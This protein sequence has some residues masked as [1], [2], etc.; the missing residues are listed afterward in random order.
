M[1]TSR[2]FFEEKINALHRVVESRNK[3]ITDLKLQVNALEQYSRRSHLRIHGLR[4]GPDEDCPSAVASLLSS[5]LKTRDGQSLVV[6][7]KDI[8]AAHPLPTRKKPSEN[9]SDRGGGATASP[10]ARDQKPASVIVRFY[11]REQ[12]DAVML[13]RRQLAGSGLSLTDDLTAANAAL[14]R[15][16]KSS[17][18]AAWSWRG[19]IFAQATEQAAPRKC[20][21][22]D[23]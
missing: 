19:K 9:A 4:L 12:R 6:E 17:N 23:N 11:S 13:A 10:S 5:R 18:F 8:D 2:K 20:D 15:R 14:L 3:E 1:E 16:L 21:L 7:R 22:F